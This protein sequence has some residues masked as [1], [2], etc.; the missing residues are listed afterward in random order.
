V[1]VDCLTLLVSNL[2]AGEGPH[3]EPGTPD[4]AVEQ[5]VLRELEAIVEAGRAASADVLLVSNEV[6]LGVVPA[7]P[8]GRHFRDLAGRAN[9]LLAREADEVYFLVAG[10]PQRLK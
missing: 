4:P 8:L 5:G 3:G 1:L 7:T 6:G 9:Q 10:L 2:L